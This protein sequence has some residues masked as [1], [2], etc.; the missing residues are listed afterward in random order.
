MEPYPGSGLVRVHYFRKE[1]P[2][3]KEAQMTHTDLVQRIV[4]DPTVCG[5]RPCIQ[6]T[7]IEA[8]VVLDAL[9]EGLTPD[10]IIDHYPSLAPEDIRAAAAYAS[11][12][13][14]ENLWRVS[15]R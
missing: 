1:N 8:S 2:V 10:E 6:G 12:L 11:D 4:L 13:A 5:G 9:A 3:Q 15:D 14:R 7:R